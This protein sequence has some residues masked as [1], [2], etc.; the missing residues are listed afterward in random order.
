[1]KYSSWKDDTQFVPPDNAYVL[2]INFKFEFNLNNDIENDLN[3][4]KSQ[5]EREGKA[6]DTE[7]EVNEIY[8]IPGFKD[9]IVC[10]SQNS[11][12]KDLFIFIIAFFFSTIGY[13]SIVNFFTYNKKTQVDATIKKS[14]SSSNI[15][16]NPYNEHSIN[17]ESIN[18]S[19]DETGDKNEAGQ[20]FEP[21]IG[22][23]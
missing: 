9:R 7:V 17:E 15:Y 13:S 2:F 14:I 6:H 12:C 11:Y 19:S 5:M 21:L 23:N 22:N 4:L 3:N 8:T 20:I 18:I 1:M 16:E 10:R